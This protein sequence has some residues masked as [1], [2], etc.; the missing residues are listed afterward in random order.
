MI[1]EF[2]ALEKIAYE[3]TPDTISCLSF[4]F[5][6][7]YGKE[8]FFYTIFVHSKSG[9][10]NMFY[11]INDAINYIERQEILKRKF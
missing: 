4:S 9:F 1:N 3:L 10:N 2:K 6:T 5:L 11:N 7:T 8:G